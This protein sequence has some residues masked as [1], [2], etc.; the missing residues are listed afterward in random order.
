MKLKTTTVQMYTNVQERLEIFLLHYRDTTIHA[1]MSELHEGLDEWVR[2]AEVR[3]LRLIVNVDPDNP[4]VSAETHRC[5]QGLAS[6]AAVEMRCKRDQVANV[7]VAPGQASLTWVYQI[8]FVLQ[9]HEETKFDGTF[10]ALAFE[11]TDLEF[12]AD[13]NTGFIQL[14]GDARPLDGAKLR[15]LEGPN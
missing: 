5:L 4:V 2:S 10:Q 7:C 3:Q 1:A 12:V 15:V 8:R 14:W 9:D 6:N 13:A 11:S